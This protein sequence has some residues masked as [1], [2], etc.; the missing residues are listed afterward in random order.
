MQATAPLP[1]RKPRIEIIPLIDIMFFLLASF[2]LVSLSMVRLRG[3][4]V[5]LPSITPLSAAI[6]ADEAL[7]LEVLAN[8]AGKGPAIFALDRQALAGDAL[9]E[10]LKKRLAADQAESRETRLLIAVGKDAR[11]AHLIEALDRV[12]EAGLQRFSFSLKPGTGVG[13]ARQADA[14]PPR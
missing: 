6:P 13:P 3:L 9:V 8:A 14:A 12:K 1:H 5:T 2:M 11:H 10:A 4:L 7:R